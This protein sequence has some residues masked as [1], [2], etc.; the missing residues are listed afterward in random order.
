MH[1]PYTQEAQRILL[2]QHRLALIQ[3]NTPSALHM[4]MQGYHDDIRHMQVVLY[5]C[6]VL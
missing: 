6:V 1:A 4:V 2:Q 3:Q 5:E